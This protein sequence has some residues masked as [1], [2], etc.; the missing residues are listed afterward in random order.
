MPK[1][2][3]IETINGSIALV[4]VE[5]IVYIQPYPHDKTKTAVFTRTKELTAI[6]PNYTQLKEMLTSI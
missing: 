6:K 3:E 2:I 1:F 4:N 5:Q